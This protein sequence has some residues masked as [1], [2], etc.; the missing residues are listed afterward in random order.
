MHF[1]IILKTP[2]FSAVVDSMCLALEDLYTEI[3]CGIHHTFI[4]NE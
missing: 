2:Y 1:A 4:L 3:Y